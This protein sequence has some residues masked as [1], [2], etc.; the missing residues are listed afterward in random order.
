MNTHTHRYEWDS[1]W[2]I[3]QKIFKRHSHCVRCARCRIHIRV[4]YFATTDAGWDEGVNGLLSRSPKSQKGWKKVSTHA[5]NGTEWHCAI[6]TF[7]HKCKLFLRSLPNVQYTP[8]T[9]L[10][11][12]PL[13]HLLSTSRSFTISVFRRL[14]F[15]LSMRQFSFLVYFWSPDQDV[16][17]VIIIN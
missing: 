15:A 17:G 4:K 2:K 5:Y 6:Y 1:K 14:S 9:G 12:L 13:F 16:F 11:A 10:N 8:C 7:E 3:N